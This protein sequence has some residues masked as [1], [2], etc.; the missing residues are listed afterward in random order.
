MG[1]GGVGGQSKAHA[2]AEDPP[3]HHHPTTTTA[4][5]QVQSVHC[6]PV[7]PNLVMT[8]GNDYTARVVD[9][10]NLMGGALLACV[11]VRAGCIWG[12]GGRLPEACV[13]CVCVVSFTA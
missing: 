5:K 2:C 8:A 13:M 11:C 1:W 3:Y 12:V 6:N 7:D 4:H 10:R 9:I